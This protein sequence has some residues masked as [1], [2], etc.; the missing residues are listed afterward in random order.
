MLHP[1]KPASDI[2]ALTSADKVGQDA[3][4]SHGLSENFKLGDY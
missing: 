2:F 3:I 1:S 4:L